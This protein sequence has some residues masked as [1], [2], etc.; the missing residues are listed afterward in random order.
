ME[1]FT[2]IT[3]GQQRAA[4]AAQVT[5]VQQ[6][7]QMI[8]QLEYVKTM[9]LAAV[10]RLATQIARDE[11][12]GDHGAM[13]HRAVEA[14]IA[15][16]TRSSQL[17]TSRRIGHAD[18]LL[19]KY[20]EVSAAFADGEVSLRHTEVIADAGQVITS[21]EGRSAYERDIIPAARTLTSGQLRL[22]AKRVAEMYAGRSIDERFA[23]ARMGRQVRVTDLDDGMAQV[24]AVVPAVEAYGI[25]D[26]LSRIA[27]HTKCDGDSRT[28]RQVQADVFT[29]LLLTAGALPEVPDAVEDVPG[30]ASG[31]GVQ[32]GQIGAWQ[33][34]AGIQ[35]RVQVSVPVLTLVGAGQ[36]VAVRG[37]GA[38]ELAGYGPIDAVTARVLAGHAPAWERVLT[39]PVSEVVLSVDRYRPNEDLKRLLG[40]RDRY[41]RFPACNRRLDHCDIDH[42]VPFSEGGKTQL[43]NAGGSILFQKELFAS[44]PLQGSHFS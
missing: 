6:I 28:L 38:P 19:T 12:H 39:H 15:A 27:Y 42:T 4:L 7:D 14:E 35:G 32:R 11:G 37:V 16:A 3:T 2:A 31:P 30:S 25:R 5:A 23:E 8:H 17:T 24:A 43:S 10:S 33:S 22:H 44:L 9:Q 20:P 26:R 40:A 13:V 41:C 36:D 34:L 1:H 29:Q 18:H 21:E